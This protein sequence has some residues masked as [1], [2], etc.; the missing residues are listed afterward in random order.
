MS[1]RQD[2][3]CRVSGPKHVH[4]LRIPI[5]SSDS[6]FRLSHLAFISTYILLELC[7]HSEI[8]HTPHSIQQLFTISMTKKSARTRRAR[9]LAAMAHAPI[10]ASEPSFFD[11]QLT[12]TTTS[13]D[14]SQSPLTPVFSIDSGPLDEQPTATILSQEDS[15]SLMT[16]VC[17]A[18][19]AGPFSYEGFRD[20]IEHGQGYCYTTTWSAIS[21]SINKNA[22]GW[23]RI[24][25]G[26]RDRLPLHWFNDVVGEESVEVSMKIWRQPRS[27]IEIVF[28]GNQ[29]TKTFYDIYANSGKPFCLQK[30]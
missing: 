30:F 5:A 26:A 27:D 10:I 13:Q 4:V 24:V 23:C 8:N 16:L 7:R 6:V 2:K 3:R 29:A 9:K 12:A 20:A 25:E 15:Q 17:S 19:R 18:C 11:E 1:F 22:C 14:D 21:Q 28:N